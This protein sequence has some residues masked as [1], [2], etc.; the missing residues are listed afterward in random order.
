M[1]VARLTTNTQ[2]TATTRIIIIMNFTMITKTLKSKIVTIIIIMIKKN[3]ITIAT[4]KIIGCT[5][6]LQ[7][8]IL[9]FE[10]SQVGIHKFLKRF[11]KLVYF[12]KINGHTSLRLTG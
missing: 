2:L 11:H 5:E 12:L 3:I 6:F 10:D 1:R 7:I 4:S 9:T 8:G